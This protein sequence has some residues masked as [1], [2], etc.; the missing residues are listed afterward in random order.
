MR[1]AKIARSLALGN[2]RADDEASVFKA[3][4]LTWVSKLRS[5]QIRQKQVFIGN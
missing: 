4:V 3:T 1:A 2:R 5:I